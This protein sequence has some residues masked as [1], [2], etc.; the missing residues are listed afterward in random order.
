MEFNY[1]TD[2]KLRELL[3]GAPDLG[4]G[5]V[6]AFDVETPNRYAD[7]V[8][9][10]GVTLIERGKVRERFECLVD[11]DTFFDDFCVS[12]HGIT[13]EDVEGEPEFPVIWDRI[14]GFFRDSLVIAH[15]AAFDLS[16]LKKLFLH[17]GIEEEPVR[18]ADTLRISRA[19]YGKRMPNHR[20]GTLCENLGIGLDAHHA[21][22][23]SLACAELY[24]R[25]LARR[26]DLSSFEKEYPFR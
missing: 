24:L 14:G 17:Y 10:I 22:S 9:S 7:R 11:P 19:V 25:M 26:G 12:V 8:C 4:P 1:I 16:V 5:R 2:D 15:N 20:L 13:P 3:A 18:Y 23:D 21:G 6:T